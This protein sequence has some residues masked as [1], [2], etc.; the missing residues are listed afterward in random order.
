MNVRRLA[1]ISVLVLAAPIAAQARDQWGSAQ[2]RDQWGSPSASSA[3]NEGYTRG[4]R[5]GE[6]DIR[7]GQSFDFRDEG[8]YRRADL[9]YRREFG[10]VDRYRND[11]RRGFEEGYRAGYRT[12][13]YVYGNGNANGRGR[14]WNNGNGNGWG[15]GNARYDLAL[16]NGYSDGY[17]EGLNDG[18][19]RH[20]N[21]PIAES[22]YR[23]GD[24]GYDR[25]YGPKETY[26]LRY[27][28][29]V[30]GRL[31]A[32]VPGRVEVPQLVTRRKPYARGTRRERRTQE[33]T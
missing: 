28:D 26:K 4:V 12:N 30:Q 24:H 10:N 2:P 19:H 31:R 17:D 8:D 20:R 6:E 16:S 21:D 25:A 9:G 5:A 14:G 3:Y 7:R 27:R 22:R 15:W 1:L 33:R 11:F 29:C 23:N 18:R 13:S 32:G